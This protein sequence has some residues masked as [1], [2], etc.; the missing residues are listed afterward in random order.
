MKN[1]FWLASYPKS[2][3]TWVRVF[4]ANLQKGGDEPVDIN[5]IGDYWASGRDLLD[6]FYGLAC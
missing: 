2:G 5:V 4:L 1:L 6:R 3:N